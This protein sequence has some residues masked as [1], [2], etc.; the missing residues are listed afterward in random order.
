LGPGEGGGTGGGAFRAG[1]NGVG[2][3]ECIYCPSPMY[4]DDARKAK[5]MGIVVLEV[6]IT[7]DGR[8]VNISIIKDPGMGLG[9]KAVE[10]VR[11]WKFRP[12]AGP[13]GKIVAVQVPIEVTFRLY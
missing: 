5:Y 8:A 4:S 10:A 7:A 9:E 2:V 3:P 12:A 11:T 13:S 1:V 6:T